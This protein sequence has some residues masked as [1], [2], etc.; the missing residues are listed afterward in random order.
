MVTTNVHEKRKIDT[1]ASKTLEH[2]KRN[3]QVE[4]ML[5]PFPVTSFVQLLLHLFLC[6]VIHSFIFSYIFVKIISRNECI[7][8]VIC[9]YSL[10]KVHTFYDNRHVVVC[11]CLASRFDESRSPSGRN[12]SC[13]WHLPGDW[14]SDRWKTRIFLR[15]PCMAVRLKLKLTVFR[16][17]IDMLGDMKIEQREKSTDR[18]MWTYVTQI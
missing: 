18:E 4:A 13:H 12:C 5:L 1:I 15:A 14:V 2:D 11:I 10:A 17:A 3:R 9:L 16:R 8:C 6:E 7:D